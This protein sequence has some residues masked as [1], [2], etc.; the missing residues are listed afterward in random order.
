MQKIVKTGPLRNS[1]DRD[2]CLQYAIAVALLHGRL[3]ADDYEDEAAADPRIDWLR[4][5][6]TVNEDPRY[7][8]I[9]RDPARRANPNAIEVLFKDGTSSGLVEVEYPVGHSSR[10]EEGL[11]ILINKFER[12]VAHRFPQRQGAI[13]ALCLDHKRLMGT[14]VNDFSDLFIAER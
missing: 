4:S 1:A 7:T 5:L 9:Y 14:S 13:G 8:E 11:P 6:M 3:T 10:R 12:S 2:H